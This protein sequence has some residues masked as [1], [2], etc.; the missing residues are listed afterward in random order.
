MKITFLYQCHEL[1]TYEFPRCIY[2]IIR[3]WIDP[4]RCFKCQFSKRKRAILACWYLVVPTDAPVRRSDRHGKV[5]L[6]IDGARGPGSCADNRRP[7]NRHNIL[8]SQET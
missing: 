8:A 6:E 7:R 5:R 2:L 3:Q 1:P 4:P